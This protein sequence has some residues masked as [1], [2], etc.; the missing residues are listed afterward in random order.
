MNPFIFVFCSFLLEIYNIKYIFYFYSL[1]GKKSMR[2]D[3]DTLEIQEVMKSKLK[4]IYKFN[5]STASVFISL[6]REVLNRS[7]SANVAVS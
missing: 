1:S 6:M 2:I 5:S 3:I 4:V 7:Q